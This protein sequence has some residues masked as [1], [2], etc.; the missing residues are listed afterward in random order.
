MKNDINI[1]INHLFELEAGKSN[2]EIRDCIVKHCLY[3]I[4]YVC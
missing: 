4:R 1:R 2:R 3:S